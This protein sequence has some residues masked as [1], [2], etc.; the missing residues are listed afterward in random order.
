MDKDSYLKYMQESTGWLHA[1]RSALIS[2]V[3]RFH[4]QKGKQNLD[5]LDVGA[6]V[7]Q[8]VSSLREFGN[9]DVLEIDELGLAE[10]RKLTGV[11]R[12]I[13]SG[14]PCV[15][16]KKYDVIGAF[17]VIEHIEDD[18]SAIGWIVE[19]LNP[20]GLF[21]VTVPA[22]RWFFSDHDRMLGHYR[23]YSAS[24]FNAIVPVSMRLL[25]ESYFNSYLFPLAIV[26][27][28]GWSLKNLMLHKGGLAKQT[29]PTRGVADK[30]LRRI[31]LAEIERMTPST[32]RGCG[33]GFRTRTS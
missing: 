11:S 27:R 12:V 30:I 25:S 7:G 2:K 24:G 10:L 26:S 23:R 21:I 22:N 8:N 5:I 16:H 18:R 33:Q 19:N 17:D 29:V 4:L 28:V 3:L 6:G 1:G 32:R 9:V 15:L 13:A 31:F 14:I 20:G